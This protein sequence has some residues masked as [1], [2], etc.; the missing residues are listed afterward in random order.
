MNAYCPVAWP[1]ILGGYTAA[2]AAGVIAV[3]AQRAL[4]PANDASSGM[5]AFGELLLFAGIAGTL[6][7]I[8]TALLLWRLRTSP[9]S[10]CGLAWGALA[11]SLTALPCAATVAAGR[12][13]YAG[14]L[15]NYEPWCFLRLL[16]APGIL[17]AWMLGAALAPTAAARRWLL[18]AGALE[19][20][21]T[22]TLVLHFWR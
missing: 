19:V 10:W 3:W 9:R 13:G 17:L 12:F 7:L 8:P 2:F 18:A 6:S 15:K 20:A 21:A 5:A 1:W 14:V 16:A 4:F 22:A 11:I